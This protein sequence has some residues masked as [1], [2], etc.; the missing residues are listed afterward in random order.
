MLTQNH[1]FTVE[2]T[3]TGEHRSFR[4]E[5][6]SPDA[7]FAPGKRILSLK[8]GPKPTDFKSFAFVSHDGRGISV[9][10][11]KQSEAEQPSDWQKYAKFLLKLQSAEAEKYAV[12]ESCDCRRCGEQLT[13]PES[14]RRG[15]GP[16]CARR[17]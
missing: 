2:N 10:K 15:I 16:V 11:S 14:I 1:T 4:I 8:V 13:V 17:E 12:L 3:E 6:Q 5:Q 9:W 7:T